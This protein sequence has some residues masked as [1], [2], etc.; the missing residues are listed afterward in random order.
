MPSVSKVW[1]ARPVIWDAAWQTFSNT[2]VKVVT[3][4]IVGMM[5]RFGRT[6]KD[7]SAS[8]PGTLRLGVALTA[9]VAATG[10][11]LF[12]LGSVGRVATLAFSGVVGAA[13]LMAVGVSRTL[14]GIGAA[15]ILTTTRI[16]AFAAGAMVLG[17]VGGHGAIFAAMGASLASFGRAVLLFPA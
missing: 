12:V 4:E 3:P 13:G 9:A 5:D 17:A 16:R 2:L 1:R 14:A 15:A 7:L 11:L 10:P 8:S 6:V